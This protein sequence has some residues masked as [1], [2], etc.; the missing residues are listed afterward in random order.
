MPGEI[1]DFLKE[2]PRN[3]LIISNNELDGFVYLD[4]G[5]KLAS[6]LKTIR[7]DRRISLK[8]ESVINELIRE[9]EK[10]HPQFGKYF[11]FKNPGILLEPELKFNLISFLENYSRDTILMVCWPGEIRGKTLHFLTEERGKKINLDHLSLL[12][13]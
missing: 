8:A 13:L 3:K 4:I 12:R 10:I 9:A 1:P 11:A 2:N 6:R 7:L 5:K